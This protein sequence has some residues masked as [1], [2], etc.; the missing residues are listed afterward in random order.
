MVT[1]KLRLFF[2]F[3][4]TD[5]GSDLR[6]NGNNG[7]NPSSVQSTTFTTRTYTLGATS[8]LSSRVSNEFRLNYSSNQGEVSNTLTNFGGATPTNL[9]QLQ[10]FATGTKPLPQVIIFLDFGPTSIL[11]SGSP[12]Q[13]KQWNL[14]DTLGLL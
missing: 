8:S 7:Q 12:G 1:N 14:V 3:S 10:G 11:E 2:S 5:S 6:Q 9:F 13:Q 4:N